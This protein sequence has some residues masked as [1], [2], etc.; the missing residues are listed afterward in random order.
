MTPID[1]AGGQQPWSPAEEP[2]AESLG[3]ALHGLALGLGLAILALAMGYS[4]QLVVAAYGLEATPG[5]G[6]L[7]TLARAWHDAMTWLGI[8]QTLQS[9]REALAAAAD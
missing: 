3:P 6:I 1:K 5:G 4:A 2:P 8:P 7:V 9:L